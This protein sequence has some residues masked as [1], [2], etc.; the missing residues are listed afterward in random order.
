MAESSTMYY[1][2]CRSVGV[3]GRGHEHPGLGNGGDGELVTDED[4]GRAPQH[5]RRP[6]WKLTKLLAP[7]GCWCSWGCEY[8][9]S[10]P[11][12]CLKPQAL[13]SM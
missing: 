12:S 6:T 9:S 10:L 2:V 5:G 8:P 4:K 3:A 1:I 13:A 7:M 11:P